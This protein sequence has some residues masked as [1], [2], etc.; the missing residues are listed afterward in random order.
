MPEDIAERC[1]QALVRLR[2]LL[3][4]KNTNDEL[5]MNDRELLRGI[6][7][8]QARG[9]MEAALREMRMRTLEIDARLQARKTCELLHEAH[10]AVGYLPT[11]MAAVIVEEIH[12][13]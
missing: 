5:E 4:S 3:Q 9:Q 11:L 10:R 7:D 8:P 6:N 1:A 2:T 12:N 13:L